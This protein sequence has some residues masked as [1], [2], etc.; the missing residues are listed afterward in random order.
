MRQPICLQLTNSE[1]F[2]V[3]KYCTIL[4]ANN[5]WN[6]ILFREGRCGGF[7]ERLIGLTKTTLKKVLGQTFVNLESLQTII[8]EIELVLNDHT[9]T[10]V[11]SETDKAEPTNTF[12]PAL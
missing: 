11:T 1:H 8:T 4:S 2:L 12:S 7:W 10:H 6:R 3:H 5:V 9:I